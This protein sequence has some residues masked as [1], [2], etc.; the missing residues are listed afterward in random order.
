MTSSNTTLSAINISFEQFQA[1]AQDLEFQF[2]FDL[3]EFYE[4][5]IVENYHKHS[6]FSNAFTPDS[7]TS[8]EAYAKQAVEYGDKCLFSGEHGSQG[9]QFLTYELCEKYG[10]KYRHST[11]AYWVKDR[12]EKDGAN[13]HIVLVAKTSKGRKDINYILSEANISGFYRKPRID[14]ELLYSLDPKDVIIT[15]ACLAGWKYEDSESIWLNLAR[16]FKGSFFF[17]VQAHPVEQQ[18]KLNKRILELSELYNIPIIAGMDSH[19]I[20]E[21]GKERRAAYQEAIFKTK[22]KEEGHETEVFYMDYPDFQTLFKRFKEQGVLNDRQILIAM[23]NTLI[24]ENECETIVFDRKFKIPNVYKGLSYS[25]REQKLKDLLNEAY[26]RDPLKS[27][28]K[29]EAIRWEVSQYIESGTVDYPLFSYNLVNRAVKKFGGQLT[30]TGRGSVASFI[31]SKLLGFTTIDRFNTSIP[32]HPE[33]FLTAERIKS[34]QMP[35]IDFNT[36]K[37]EPFIDAA[38]DLLGEYGAYPILTR[39]LLKEKSAWQMYARLEEIPAQDYLTISKGIDSYQKELKYAEEEERDSINV[40]D[41]INPNYIDIYQ[42]SLDFQKITNKIGVHP[43]AVLCFDGDIRREIGL[44]SAMSEAKKTRTIIANIDGAYLDSFG[45]LKQDF[46]EVD[47]VAL[48][49]KLYHSIGKEV[50][51][52][53]ELKTLVQD[54]P[55][56]WKIYT[57][58]K[59]MCVNQCEG[60]A[61]REKVRRYKPKNIEE[62]CSFVA[63]IRPGFKS[64]VNTFLDRKPYSTGETQIDSVLEESA[65]FLLY[66]ESIMTIL[67]FLGVDMK[68]TYTIIKSISK[69]KLKG[70]KKD[71]LLDKLKAGW[72]KR[73]GNMDNFNKVWAVIEDSA[74]YAFNSPHSYSMAGDSLYIAYFKAHYPDQFF[75]T[76]IS[77]YQEKGSKQKMSSLVKEAVDEFGYQ[78]G[79]YNFFNDHRKTNVKD[80]IIYPPL[81]NIKGFGNALAEELYHLKD[82]YNKENLNS[83]DFFNL[84]LRIKNDSE[85]SLDKTQ[86]QQL[87]KINYF[88][89]FGPINTLL[90]VYFLAYCYADTKGRIAKSKL[91]KW[92]LDVSLACCFGKETDKQ[93]VNFDKDGYFKELLKEIK[94]RPDDLMTKCRYQMEVL[95]DCNIVDP[96]MNGH[97]FFVLEIA[98]KNKY[99][100]I[101]LYQ[102]RSGK[103]QVLKFWKTQTDRN[104]IKEGDHLYIKEFDKRYKRV[105]NG[106]L[107]KEGKQIWVDDKDH[108]ELW[109]KGYRVC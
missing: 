106:E 58:N 62:L 85:I 24:F 100:Y 25:Q 103:R 75:E 109:L 20:D 70:K 82:E 48:T 8:M 90:Q 84:V 33:R 57:S 89:D 94:S 41:F 31:T 83:N 59:L 61:T 13:C 22:D 34:G 14:L 86:L 30:T 1:A 28:E 88:K 32:I 35:D 3:K 37:Q 99:G 19:Y 68:E 78:L 29:I 4:H 66:Q 87:I 67:S 104:P 93:I 102:P 10:L 96:E 81:S 11:E 74:S 12:T 21:V 39:T 53:E 43:C 46:L 27:K 45:Y 64:L 56:T 72:M 6:D 18:M 5:P 76:A 95:G 2:P 15:S 16:H 80:S 105:W 26:K 108:T 51:T 60:Q 65:H 79:D 44:I 23:L 7:T 101:H 49:Y 63:A 107:T 71:D 17:E 91:E 36:G 40:E 42:R 38:R 50:P 92:N 54:D 69:K 47:T 55:E 77:H 98:E 97:D 9:D 52:F 73:F